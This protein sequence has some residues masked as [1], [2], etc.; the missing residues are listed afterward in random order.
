MRTDTVTNYI[1][2]EM[3]SFNTVGK[4]SFRVTRKEISLISQQSSGTPGT[5]SLH[6]TFAFNSS[7]NSPMGKSQH[8]RRVHGVEGS[9]GLDRTPCIQGPF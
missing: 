5:M 6:V 4:P 1:S 7:V 2:K 9:G 8:R 3:V